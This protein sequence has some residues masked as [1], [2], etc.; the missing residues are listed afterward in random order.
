LEIEL[1]SE[2]LARLAPVT[3]ADSTEA[4]AAI[5][6]DVLGAGAGAMEVLAA[7][8]VTT[9]DAAGAKE[10]LAAVLVTTDG[11]AGAMEVLAEGPGLMVA[12]SGYFAV[13]F[14]SF[15]DMLTFFFLRII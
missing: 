15:F 9:D 3:T 14:F 1:L 12:S 8:L 2:F 7:V 13:N 10:V 6:A 11:A 4:F 5:L